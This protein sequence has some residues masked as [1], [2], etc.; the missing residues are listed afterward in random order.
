MTA[1][2]LIIADSNAATLKTAVEQ[3]LAKLESNVDYL[4]F[5]GRNASLLDELNITDNRLESSDRSAITTIKNFTGS[6]AEVELQHY[7]HIVIFGFQ[8]L[9]RESGMDWISIVDDEGKFLSRGA[10]AA[11][12]STENNIKNTLHFRFAEKCSQIAPTIKMYS[13]PSPLPNEKHP[14]W[15]NIYGRRKSPLGKYESCANTLLRDSN[16]ELISLPEQLLA[17]NYYSISEDYWMGNARDFSHLNP[18]GA[19]VLLKHMTDIMGIN[20]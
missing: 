17:D 9:S 7:S 4:V 13:I 3:N 6:E 1:R 14:A 12:P 16:I 2:I 19:A 5:S 10:I 20:S 8:L 15:R 11:T 18:A